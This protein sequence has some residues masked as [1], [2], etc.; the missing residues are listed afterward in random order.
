MLIS[1][2]YLKVMKNANY[3][4][5]V[6]MVSSDS[7]RNPFII[8]KNF[9]S[10]GIKSKNDAEGYFRKKLEEFSSREYGSPILNCYESAKNASYAIMLYT[11]KFWLGATYMMLIKGESF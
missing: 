7:F 2:K 4:K 3:F 1:G 11:V 5:V 10:D 8:E 6:E 9:E